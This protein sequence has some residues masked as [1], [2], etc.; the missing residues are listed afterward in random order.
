M[1]ND[2]DTIV[3]DSDKSLLSS[4]TIIT[5]DT[6]SKKL[7]KSVRFSEKK[8]VVLIPT[9]FENR[10]YGKMV[11]FNKN[12]IVYTIPN[13][14]KLF[15]QQYGLENN[16]DGNGIG[17]LKYLDDFRSRNSLWYTSDEIRKLSEDALKAFKIY[18]C[19][20]KKEITIPS[21]KTEEK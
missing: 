3:C 9:R 18:I 2:D 5:D 16:G 1:I 21:I 14:R 12:I 19:K 11:T 13:R 6:S 7:K 8:Q 4:Q 20:E 10:F 15:L 17:R